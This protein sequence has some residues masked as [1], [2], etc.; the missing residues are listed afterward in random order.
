[1]VHL[2]IA[3]AGEW[4]NLTPSEEVMTIAERNQQ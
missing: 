1:M 4:D 2:Y 3:E